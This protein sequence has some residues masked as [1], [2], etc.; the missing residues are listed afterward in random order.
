MEMA[1]CK[2]VRPLKNGVA[3]AEKASKPTSAKV[4]CA[5]MMAA[6]AQ[7]LNERAAL[8]EVPMCRWNTV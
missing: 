8:N 7:V 1:A 4:L 2:T 3:R 5:A 6:C